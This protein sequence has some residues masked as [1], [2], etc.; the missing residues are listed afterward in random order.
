MP[1][2]IGQNAPKHSFRKLLKQQHFREVDGCEVCGVGG[3][4]R[5]S[6]GAWA[7]EYRGRVAAEM[8]WGVAGRAG[9][10]PRDGP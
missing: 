3:S 10:G 1:G 5:G 6:S 7:A 8:D 9:R 2:I 4:E